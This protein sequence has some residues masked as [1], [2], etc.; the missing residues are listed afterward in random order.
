MCHPYT[1]MLSSCH[2]TKKREVLKAATL[3]LAKS[4]DSYLAY[5]KEWSKKMTLHHSSTPQPVA[6]NTTITILILIRF[7]HLS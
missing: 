5:L 2:G 6:D 4:L 7:W 1:M 3:T